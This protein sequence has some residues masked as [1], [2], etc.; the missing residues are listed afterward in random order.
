MPHHL[1]AGFFRLPFFLRIFVV[2]IALIL[3]FG[4]LIYYIEPDTFETPFQGIWWAIITASTV[5]YGDIVPQSIGGKLTGMLFILFGA[6]FVSTYIVTL[7][8][9]AV[10]RHNAFLEGRIMFKGKDHIIVVGWNER[11]KEIILKL[12]KNKTSIPVVLIDETLKTNPLKDFHVHFIQGR[13][14]VDDVLKRAKII[15]AKNVVITADQN[16][17]ELQADMH[18]ILTLL[19]VKGLNP[20][21]HCI[22]E[23]LTAEQTENA[24]RAGADQII[25]SNVITS[26]VMLNCLSGDTRVDSLLGLLEQLDGNRVHFRSSTSFIGKKFTQANYSLLEENCLLLGV[27][28]GEETY[29]N[30]PPS[31]IIKERDILLVI[32][33]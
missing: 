32:T 2:A 8:K 7:S 23:V 13:T 29:V 22:A 33:G 3:F 17:D 10:S 19:A 18:T 5:G 9:V 1:Y 21:V 20:N 14:N 6:G 16:K 15:E 24:K 11:A 26:S 12:L 25:Q 31:F 28:R 30:P 27:K 4:V